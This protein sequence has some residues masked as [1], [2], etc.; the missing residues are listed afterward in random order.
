MLSFSFSSSRQ[1]CPQP[2]KVQAILNKVA[3]P[4]TAC[5][6]HQFMGMINYYRDHIHKC[7]HLLAPLTTQSK[8]KTKINWTP[9]CN[10]S[11]NQLKSQL[12]QQTMLSFPNPN[13]PFILEPDASDYQLGCIILQNTK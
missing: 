10:N 3:P 6:L 2:E 9:E 1:F 13:L 5:Q 4:T 12:A 11:F 7:S 8:N